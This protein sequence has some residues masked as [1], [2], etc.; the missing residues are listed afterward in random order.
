MMIQNNKPLY[1]YLHVPFCRTIC[2]YCDF[3]HCVYQESLADQWLDALQK[4]I[5]YKEINPHLRT[6][7]LGGGTP[8]S[9]SCRQLERLLKM[10]D[11]YRSETEE[12]TVEI[13]PETLDDAKASLMASHGIN[14]ASVGFQTSNPELLKLMGRHHDL[15]MM[16]QT[17]ERLHRCG[18]HN[19]SLDLMYSLPGQTMA[20]LAQSIQDALSLQPVHLSLYSLTIE[21]HTLFAKKDL[22]HLSD[23]AEA[24]MYESIEK[25]LPQYGFHQYE[26]SN[27]ALGDHESIHNKAYWNYQDFYG[28]SAGASGKE[29]WHRYDHTRILAEY[30][31]DPLKTQDIPLSR[32]EA[33]FEMIM[34]GLRLKCGVSR[35]LF[36]ET[37][38]EEIMDVYGEKAEKLID[39]GLLEADPL[40]LKASDR[41][42]EILN[43]VLVDLM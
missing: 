40:Y 29:G 28:I 4:E 42:Y 37:F 36:A 35:K 26:I 41:G 20:D 38:Q 39:Q 19:I 23:D 22:H 17:V 1:L 13:N 32:K 5:E 2:S 3:A 30:L 10:L 31:K 15:P 14:R 16:H 6:I 25:T 24:D 9:L 43:T 7:Y 8:T 18:I 12:Y 21:P 33:M 27:F 34:M 11:P